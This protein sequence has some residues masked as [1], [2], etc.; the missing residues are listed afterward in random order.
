MCNIAAGDLQTRCCSRLKHCDMNAIESFSVERMNR[1][2]AS[3]VQV[4]RVRHG[5]RDIG[6][7]LEGAI[8][9]NQFECNVG[10]IL[11]LT[12]DCPFE[13]G[14]SIYLL[15]H[16]YDILDR[17]ELS[18]P[19]STGWIHG[20][21]IREPDSV[22]FSFYGDD[23]WELT[24]LPGPKLKIM[25]PFIWPTPRGMWVRRGDI[26]RKRYCNLKCLRG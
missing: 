6:L 10:Y 1:H 24:M 16:Q 22:D 17:Y 4:V 3:S 9:E 13:E 11:F 8:L 25:L 20:V 26:L 23:Q 5:S 2:D 12:H 19:Y 21:V 15:G 7:T 18:G 14:L